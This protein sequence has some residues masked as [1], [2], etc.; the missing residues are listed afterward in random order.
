[1][2]VMEAAYEKLMADPAYQAVTQ[3]GY[4]VIRDNRIELFMLLP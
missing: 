2:A 4:T 1:M 3:K